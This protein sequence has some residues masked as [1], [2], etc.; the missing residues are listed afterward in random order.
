MAEFVL[1][2]VGL[3]VVYISVGIIT[4]FEDDR[5]LA[6]LGLAIFWPIALPILAVFCLCR[7]L[8]CLLLPLARVIHNRLPHARRQQ[9]L[10]IAQETI[11]RLELQHRSYMDG[12]MNEDE[13]KWRVGVYGDY[14][15]TELREVVK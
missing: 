5:C 1:Y 13:A 11:D 9:R 12:L 15:P 4:D 14:Q 8:Y 10:L 6:G 7:L 2:C 3:L